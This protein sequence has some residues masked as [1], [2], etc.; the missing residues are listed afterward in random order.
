MNGDPSMK[1]NTSWLLATILKNGGCGFP[2]EDG[3]LPH[4]DE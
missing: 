2:I 1:E 4:T 3:Y